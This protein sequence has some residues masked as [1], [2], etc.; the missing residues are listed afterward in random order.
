MLIYEYNWI[1]V[2]VIE[3]FS[4]NEKGFSVDDIKKEDI[5]NKWVMFYMFHY[6]SSFEK[7]KK[8]WILKVVTVNNVKWSNFKFQIISEKG[9]FTS[10]KITK[11]DK[12]REEIKKEL[13]IT[14]FD[15]SKDEKKS[16]ELKEISINYNDLVLELTQID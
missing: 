7:I 6:K 8:E 15:Y 14:W 16:K 3:Y 4:V 12:T 13:L 11:I 1:N 10:K 9:V 5:V 2:N